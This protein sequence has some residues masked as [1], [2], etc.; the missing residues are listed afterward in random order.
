MLVVE[1][2]SQSTK[3]VR[4]NLRLPQQKTRVVPSTLQ[5]LTTSTTLPSICTAR[6]EDDMLRMTHH[7]EAIVTN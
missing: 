6:A 4:S 1:L 7:E 5:R 2:V 3:D